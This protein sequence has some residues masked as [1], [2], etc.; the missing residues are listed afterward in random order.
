[1]RDGRSPHFTCIDCL[2]YYGPAEENDATPP[3][4]C[5]KCGGPVVVVRLL[6]AKVIYDVTGPK[7]PP[8]LPRYK[9]GEDN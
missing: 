9:V 8:E 5:A 3:L 2:A 4:V 1:M 7:P 6:G